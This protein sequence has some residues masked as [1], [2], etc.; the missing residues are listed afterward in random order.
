MSAVHDVGSSKVHARPS[1]GRSQFVVT[2][3][4]VVAV[5]YSLV[6][7]MVS[8]ALEPLRAEF[9]ATTSQITWV[10]I[11]FLLASAVAT[12]VVGRLG[13]Q[14]GNGRVIVATT[15][16]IVV[17]SII[18]A[19]APSLP[20]LIVG[21][22]IQGIGGA[23]L[24]LAFGLLREV[25]PPARVGGTV[26]MVVAL[27][28]VGGGVGLLVAGPIVD[29]LGTDWLFWLPA[30]VNAIVAVTLFVGVPRGHGHGQRADWWAV[31][32]MSVFLVS[33]LLVL[34]LGE[35]WGWGS[36]RTLGAVIVALV[37]APIWVFIELRSATPIIDMRMMRE[38]PVVTANVSSFLFGVS[39]YSAFG[40]IPSF[41]QLPA[42][43]GY[44]LGE[45][46]TMS[47]VIFAPMTGAML[48]SGLTA[49]RLTQR[50]GAHRLVAVTS[51]LPVVGF[52]LLASFHGHSW[53]VVAATTFAGLGFGIALSALSALVVESV[54]SNQT[55]AA[56]GMNANIRS[57]GGAAGAALIG[58]VLSANQFRG[59]PTEHGYVVTFIV[60]AAASLL[61]V[62]GALAIPVKR[63]EAVHDL[64]ALIGAAESAAE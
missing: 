5:S 51:L 54:S 30:I 28:A 42:S 21:R 34:S 15:T 20:L 64:P 24:P 1:P 23:T 12:P 36:A 52:G 53:Q 55:G 14:L 56:T 60:I 9:D 17:G 59:L 22:V 16:A 45:S 47:G 46:V 31:T 33:T 19:V 50:F 18:C 48:V 43:T 39:L 41:V 25:L 27:T 11:G 37:S 8:P 58:A 38:R 2:A 32:A 7:S 40:F 29:H 35:E 3:L 4:A 10:L 61:A 63:S 6:Q 26:G 13:D 57:I 62:L 44:G 49:G